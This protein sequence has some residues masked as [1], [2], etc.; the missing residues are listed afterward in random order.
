MN[1]YT[2]ISMLPESDMSHSLR[3]GTLVNI[4]PALTPTH[5]AHIARRQ[6]RAARLGE[7]I[8]LAVFE[9]SQVDHY[10][11]SVDR[12]E[13]N[14]ALDHEMS[15]PE[16]HWTEIDGYPIADWQYEVANGD[17]RL[18]YAAWAL[19]KAMEHEE[20]ENAS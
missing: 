3:E 14:A 2:V 11:P 15:V 18:G 6:M 10:E 12:P 8:T 4:I 9:G 17:T 7:C 5:A 13:R 1:T 19:A 16:D 20:G